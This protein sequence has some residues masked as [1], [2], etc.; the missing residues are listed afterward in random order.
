[1]S[2]LASKSTSQQESSRFSS[3]SSSI[4]PYK[5]EAGLSQVGLRN[6][7]QS[8]AQQCTCAWLVYYM[9]WRS[10]LILPLPS[11]MCSTV[12]SHVPSHHRKST[13]LN[14]RMLSK[15]YSGESRHCLCASW[16]RS[17]NASTSPL[18]VFGP[19]QNMT[20]CPSSSPDRD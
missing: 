13:E 18:A 11:G 12:R 1:M 5:T 17:R 9:T 8:E 14:G 7:Y 2:P 20:S 16:L 4:T 10:A 19:E 3:V 6:H 15:S